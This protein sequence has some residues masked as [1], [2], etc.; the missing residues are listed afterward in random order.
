MG[1]LGAGES[2]GEYV[3]AFRDHPG[4]EIVG[5]YS[6]TPGSGRRLLEVH[7]VAA[8]EYSSDEQ[9]FNDDRVQ[10]VVSATPPDARPDHVVRAAE[11]GRH[12]V[13]EKPLALDM[14]SVHRMRHAVSKAG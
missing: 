14:E 4:A 8:H 2:A 3:K 11:T 1:V 10:I 12:I 9:L 5:I 6:R 7:H 13:I